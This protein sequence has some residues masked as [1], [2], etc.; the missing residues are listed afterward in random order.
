MKTL[1]PRHASEVT[2]Q[3]GC[4]YPEPFKTRMGEVSWRAL[5][6]VFG[7]TQFGISLETLQPKAESA[8]RHWHALEDEFV[9]L[10]SGELI[11]RTSDGE[12]QLSPGMCV[13]FKAGDD[14]AHHLVNQSTAEAQYLVLGS[15]VAGDVAFYPD[16]D[17]A[18]FFTDR[19][20]TA[21][22]KDGSPYTV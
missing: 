15:R 17:L 9:Y 18:W 10:L 4:S 7:L 20:R 22:H 2:P 11:L 6:D 8:L 13:G 19:G 5:G 3:T 12:F 1:I 16:D 21:N 14:N